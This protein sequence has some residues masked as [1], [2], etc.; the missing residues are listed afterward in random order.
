MMLL[1][2][3]FGLRGENWTLK[4]QTLLVVDGRTYDA[5]DVVLTN[6]SER[7]LYFDVTDWLNRAAVS[8]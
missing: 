4:G 7:R 5:Y 8:R 2:K 6:G 1:A 3:W